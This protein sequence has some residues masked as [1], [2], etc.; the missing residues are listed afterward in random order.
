[1]P[2]KRPR[3]AVA[4]VLFIVASPAI[5]AAQTL[6]VRIVDRQEHDTNYSYVVPGSV[7]AQSNSNANCVG[8]NRS[9][10][11]SASTTTTGTVLPPQHVSFSVRGATFTLRVPDG[12]LVVVNCESKFKERFAGHQGNRRSCR[13]PLIDDIQVEFDGD[14]AKLQWPV[15]IDGKKTQSETY[16]ILGILNGQ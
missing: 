11:C 7:F 15:S 9:V 1:M 8:A 13:V 3:A 2:S 10:N 16:K 6:N 14:N 4:S 5:Y 12:R